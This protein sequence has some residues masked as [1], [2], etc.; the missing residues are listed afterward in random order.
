MKLAYEEEREIEVGQGSPGEE[1]L[2]G[3][4]NKLELENDLPQETLSTGPNPHH[5]NSRMQRSE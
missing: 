5:V 2:D 4:I 1:Q 3:I